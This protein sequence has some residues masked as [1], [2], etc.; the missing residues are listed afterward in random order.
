M[1][2]G[3]FRPFGTEAE[4]A[5]M[6]HRRVQARQA[7]SGI[8]VLVELALHLRCVNALGVGALDTKRSVAADCSL[9]VADAHTVFAPAV[10]RV[11]VLDSRTD[12]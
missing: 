9:R 5:A 12:G 6:S 4:K 8:A 11:A 1:V 7:I 3:G 2:I 10:V